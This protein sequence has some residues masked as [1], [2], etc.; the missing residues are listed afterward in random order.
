M[1]DVVA[2]LGRPRRVVLDALLELGDDGREEVVVLDGGLVAGLDA[3]DERAWRGVKGRPGVERDVLE[4]QVGPL[5][6][7]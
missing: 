6:A 7:L 4:R 2:D 5:D 1:A 3:L